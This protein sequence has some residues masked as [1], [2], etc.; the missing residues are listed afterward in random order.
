MAPSRPVPRQLAL[1]AVA[2]LAVVVP[3]VVFVLTYRTT[4]EQ[5]RERAEAIAGSAVRALDAELA[6]GRHAVEW[7]AMFLGR[8]T[9]SSPEACPAW[10]PVGGEL[11]QGFSSLLFASADGA[12]ICVVGDP[13]AA[14]SRS[15]PGGR[16]PSLRET[17]WFRRAVEEGAPVVEARGERS[18][19]RDGSVKIARAVRTAS[20]ELAG[21]VAV[22]SRPAWFERVLAG[23]DVPADT[24]ITV[25]GRD[26]EAVWSIVADT[27]GSIVRDAGSNVRDVEPSTPGGPEP[28][29]EEEEGRDTGSEGVLGAVSVEAVTSLGGWSARVTLPPDMLR[30]PVGRAAAGAGILAVVTVLFAGFLA[31]WLRRRVETPLRVLAERVRAEGVAGVPSLDVKGA[32]EVREVSDSFREVLRTRDRVEARLREL[33]RVVQQTSDL[34][35]LTDAE[36]RIRYVNPAFESITGYSS[37]EA[38]GRTLDLLESRVAGPEAELAEAT[39]RAS[40]GTRSGRFTSRR[41]DGSSFVEDRTATRIHDDDG[42]V[43]GWAVTGRDITDQRELERHLRQGEKREAVGRLA[44][45]IAHAFGNIFTILGTGVEILRSAAEDRGLVTMESQARELSEASDVGVRLVHR[46]LAL[47]YRHVEVPERVELAGAVEDSV[48][49]LRRLVPES[50]SVTVRRTG[51]GGAWTVIDPTALSQLLLSLTT[52]AAE[53][54]EEGGAVV[55]EV[56]GPEPEAGADEVHEIGADEAPEAGADEVSEEGAAGAWVGVRVSDD[57]EGIPSDLRDRVVEPFFTTKD[58]AAGLG[59]TLVAET[60]ESAGGDL[61]IDSEP[62]RGTTVTAR[63]PYHPP[64]RPDEG[65]VP[66]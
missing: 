22:R 24:R 66:A 13:L 7:M 42:A 2:A 45:Q 27:A 35:V 29:G 57:G 65:A 49:V 21:V 25:S 58:D 8:E 48:R 6:D 44:G 28:R 51:S 3:L 20:G 43:V 63:L 52:N 60:V 30:E 14:P 59:L 54:S 55:I 4:H 15:P 17:P 62:G 31:G 23:L 36:G 26:G 18:H 64:E 46:L 61:R 10:F 33:S 32:K 19:A 37:E 47:S 38:T 41:K 40:A 50:I 34:V 11:V 39:G 53:A 12:V 16:S 56:F 1:L 9:P 5:V